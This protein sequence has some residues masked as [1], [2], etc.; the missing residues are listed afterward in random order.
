VSFSAT[1]LRK[2]I[3]PLASV[4]ITASPMLLSVTCS[5]F[6]LSLSSAERFRRSVKMAAYSFVDIAQVAAR[7]I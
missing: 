3:L 2:V 5:R 6:R 7:L 4:T 1:G